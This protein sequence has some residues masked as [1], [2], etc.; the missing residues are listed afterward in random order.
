M[1]EMKTKSSGGQASKKNFYW[2]RC[3]LG[4]NKRK[5]EKSLKNDRILEALCMFIC[6]PRVLEISFYTKKTVITRSYTA[7]LTGY[8]LWKKGKSDFN[9]LSHTQRN[10]TKY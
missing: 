6:F 4:N 3:G 5:G 8:G 2:V 9:Q 7:C 1:N 10:Y